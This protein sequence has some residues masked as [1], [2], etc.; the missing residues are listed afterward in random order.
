MPHSSFTSPTGGEAVTFDLNG[1]TYHC[2]DRLPAGTTL[3]IASGIAG[4]IDAA[5]RVG[6]FFDAALLPEDAEPFA[7]AIR[8]PEVPVPMETLN[9]IIQWLVQV[10]TGRPTG[11]PPAS[12]DGRLTIA[13]TSTGGA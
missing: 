1:V 8:D 3:D 9:A 5:R 10:Y 11:S 13:P 12:G 2:R 6:E 7:A 4:G